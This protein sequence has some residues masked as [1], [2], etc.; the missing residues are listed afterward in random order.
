[1]DELIPVK[2]QG[3]VVD[4]VSRGFAVI[5]RDDISNKWLPIY[6]GPFE[7]Q[8]IAQALE[9]QKFTRPGTHDLIKNIIDDLNCHIVKVTI[10]ELQDSTFFAVITVMTPA[11]EKDIDSR[12]SDAIA[13]AV[14]AKA[15]VFIAKKV[16]L[17]AGMDAM[18]KED[19]RSVKMR[20]LQTRLNDLIQQE[21][22]EEAAKLRDEM[23]RIKSS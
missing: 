15:P 23:N 12:P 20:E 6:I 14:R 1:M 21:K 5:L 10:T 2:I 19:E 13:V 22:Y 3:V 4:P 11:G 16:I 9:G 8:S 7:A 18:P 17:Q